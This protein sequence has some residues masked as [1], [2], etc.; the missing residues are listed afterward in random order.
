MTQPPQD[1]NP[2]QPG[3]QNPYAAPQQPAAPQA[4]QYAPPAQPAAPSQPYAAPGPQQ[5]YAQQQY[6]QQ[7]AYGYAAPQYPAAPVGTVPGPG[8]Y[9]DGATDPDDISRP[10]YGASFGQAV[11][12]Y[13]KQYANFKGRASRSE[14]WWVALF[15]FL[16][17][18]VPAVLVTIGIV[19]TAV[20][21]AST[22]D[23]QF[24]YS[25]GAP[26][27]FGIF[28]MVI[29]W[30]LL[31]VVALGL[32][33]PS[34]AIAWR[35]LHDGNFPGPLYFLTFV[36]YVGSLILLVFTLLPSKAEGRRFD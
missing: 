10:L 14:Y 26:S 25:Y 36:P 3:E 1:P 24:G 20:S 8:G 9:F 31:V 22:Y 23:P 15:I 12:R 6:A 19:V 4:P 35:R 13:F 34:I 21:A 17:E 18:L 7:P 5:P 27:G 29:G 16:V 30:I 32:L 2:Q 33:V 11:S 28:L